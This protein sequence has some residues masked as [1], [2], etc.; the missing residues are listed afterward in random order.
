MTYKE[1]V[2]SRFCQ[3]VAYLLDNDLAKSKKDVA[4]RLGI[5]AP[6]L[7]EILKGRMKAGVDEIQKICIEYH[8]RLD[9][10]FFGGEE[11]EILKEDVNLNVNPSVN[12]SSE[13]VKE[14]PPPGPCP[15]CEV[16]HQLIDA[17]DAQ[18]TAQHDA[19]ESLKKN[20]ALM[21]EKCNRLQD[22]LREN[23]DSDGQKRKTA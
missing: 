5:S 18:I 21:D 15:N 16:L 19:I 13:K 4:E 12:L 7:S 8:V 17:K 14:D 22:T 1:E 6:K 20:A 23:T 9:Y 3:A 2:N 11:G 10:L